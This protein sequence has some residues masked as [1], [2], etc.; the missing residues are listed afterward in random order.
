[1]QVLEI[2]RI[3]ASRLILKVTEENQNQSGRS[4]YQ[5]SFGLRLGPAHKPRPR[6]AFNL[7][8]ASRP[9]SAL[10][11]LRPTIC[12]RLRWLLSPTR[13]P[14]PA[15]VPAESCRICSGSSGS[16]GAR[17]AL[18]Q[19]GFPRFCPSLAVVKRLVHGLR[20]SVE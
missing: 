1:M 2:S 18:P 6:P 11:T 20:V 16:R 8:V 14:P 7:V 17:F 15:I 10:N 12:R 5:V 4:R 9:L 3:L 19:E 13:R